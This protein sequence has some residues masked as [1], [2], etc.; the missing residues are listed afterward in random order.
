MRNSSGGKAVATEEGHC[1]H[2]EEKPLRSFGL[3][4]HNAREKE[5]VERLHQLSCWEGSITAL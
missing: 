4:L 5:K 1:L 3:F 2:R